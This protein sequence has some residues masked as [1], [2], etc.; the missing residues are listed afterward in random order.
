MQALYYVKCDVGLENESDLE[1]YHSGMWDYI[2][3]GQKTHIIT[4]YAQEL[5]LDSCPSML[6]LLQIAAVHQGS[7]VLSA[8]CKI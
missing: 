1:T 3:P 8:I 7:R 5:L 4:N 2:A 6:S